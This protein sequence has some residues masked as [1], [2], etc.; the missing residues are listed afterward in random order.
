MHANKSITFESVTPIKSF[1]TKINS[2]LSTLYSKLE[3]DSNHTYDI[4]YEYLC[5]NVP[6]AFFNSVWVF[7]QFTLNLVSFLPVSNKLN[8]MINH[9]T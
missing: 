7:D 4:M 6:T 3:L 1:L 2:G 9:V 8:H 5:R